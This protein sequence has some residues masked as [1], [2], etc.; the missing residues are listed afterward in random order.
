MDNNNT[1][2]NK[3]ASFTR[4]DIAAILADT[5][6][7]SCRK[8]SGI[9]DDLIGILTQALCQNCDITLRGFG[10]LRTVRH[11]AKP[12]RDIAA[13]QPIVIPPHYT[14]RFKPSKHLKQALNDSEVLND[15]E[16]PND[17][18]TPNDN[19]KQ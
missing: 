15:N 18:E 9:V 19:D 1:T 8:A 12:A 6:D 2:N 13:G 4:H 5:Q 14:V 11:N 16:D 17:N 3:K 7:I 10:T